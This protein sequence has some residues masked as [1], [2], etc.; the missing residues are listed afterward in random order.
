MPA[1][2]PDDL[3]ADVIARA[4][5]GDRAA[6]E[7]IVRRYQRPV[8]AWAAAHAP[9]GAD[10]DEIAQRTF[11]AAFTRLAEFRDGTHFAA[12]LFAIARFQL[13]TEATR[14]RRLADYHSRYA[15]DLL[16]RTRAVVFTVVPPLT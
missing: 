16:A 13:M 2:P 11:V 10:A 9:P 8:R 14:L 12:W 4:R 1:P 5:G 15:P 7:A 6:F 3:P